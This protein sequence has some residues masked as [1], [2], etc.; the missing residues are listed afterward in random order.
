MTRIEPYSPQVSVWQSCYNELFSSKKPLLR[1]S[2]IMMTA[3]VLH[4]ANK[5]F[6]KAVILSSAYQHYEVVTKLGTVVQYQGRELGQ[7]GKNFPYKNGD[8]L[9]T[10]S[11]GLTCY[12][13]KGPDS[14]NFWNLFPHA[15]EILKLS[16]LCSA[17]TLNS[18][19]LSSKTCIVLA[20][21]MGILAYSASNWY[22]PWTQIQDKNGKTGEH[23]FKIALHHI[24]SSI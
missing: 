14:I 23:Y 15:W 19:T 3:I 12:T 18:T 17:C 13:M 24:N 6:T 2:V 11:H 16:F 1:L 9:V 20:I 21:P 7:E 10:I 22:L 8:D 5:Y 4:V